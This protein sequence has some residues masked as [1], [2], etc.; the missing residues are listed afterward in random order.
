MAYHGTVVGES[1]AAF[2]LNK[3]FNLKN[4]R[5]LPDTFDW[6]ADRMIR[7]F[8]AP[9]I[10]IERSERMGKGL[11]SR[12]YG[13][14]SY[15]VAKTDFKIRLANDSIEMSTF[16]HEMSHHIDFSRRGRSDHRQPFKRTHEEVI[17]A[18]VS[19][20]LVTRETLAIQNLIIFGETH[21]DKAVERF[22]KLTDSDKELA[23]KINTSFGQYLPFGQLTLPVWKERF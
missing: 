15:N 11:R 2:E 18:L 17:L 22:R 14:W 13:R 5:V 16:I 9:E 12:T 19:N 23:L 4:I 3:K 7:Y 6:L 20:R 1:G 8:D 21:F 10:T